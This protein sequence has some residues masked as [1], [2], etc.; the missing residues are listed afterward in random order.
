MLF[1]LNP[2]EAI[3][4]PFHDPEISTSL[5]ARFLAI[6]A[7][8]VS[9]V[10]SWD[11]TVLHWQDCQ[12][13][14]E[15]AA[16]EVEADI[17]PSRY[18][19]L[20]FS[21]TAPL[22]VSVRVEAKVDGSWVALGEAVRGSGIRMEVR[23]PFQKGHL[24]S[25]RACFTAGAAGARRIELHW[26]AVADAALSRQLLAATT[27]WDPAWPGLI[28]PD[29]N[30]RAVAFARGLVFDAAE[31]DRLRVKRNSPGWSDHFAILEQRA[32]R[33]MQRVPETDLGDYLPWSDIRYI[34]AREQGREP[35]FWEALTL[36]FVGLVNQDRAMQRHALRYLMCMVHT[37]NWCQS[38]ESRLT[39]STWDQRCFLEEMTV[40]SVAL[41]LD[42]FHFALTPHA[43]SLAVQALWDKGLSVIERDMM[44][45]DYVHYNN[46]GPWF[47]RARVL[48]GL[49]LEANWPR[50]GQ[51]TDRA[52]AAM[53]AALD[54]YIL[55][56]GGVDEGLGYFSVTLHATLTATIAF[57]R[58]RSLDVGSL[59]PK[60]L[61]K[62]ED[63]LAAMSA[64][65]PGKVLLDGDNST[66]YLIGDTIPIMAGLFPGSA[67][68]RIVAATLLKEGP[69]TYYNQYVLDGLLGFVLGPDE[70]PAAQ[71]IVP[72]FSV[73]PET[74]HLTS[75][76][77]DF[78]HSVRLHLAGS[79][80]NPSHSHLDKGGFT[81]ELDGVPFLIDRGTVRYDDARC[82]LLHR[83]AMH[84]V[85]TPCYD[86]TTFPDQLSPS[87][88]AIPSG[89]GDNGC[90]EAFIDLGNVWRGEMKECRRWISAGSLEAW[91]VRDAGS[92]PREGQV[93]FHLH[94]PFPFVIAG[95]TAIVEA[96]GIRLEID[97]PWAKELTACEDLIDY[98]FEPIYHLQIWSGAMV[99][100]D[101]TTNFRAFR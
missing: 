47:C 31:L 13:G 36:G 44:K 43:R 83:S 9:H 55:P 40:T 50:L 66:N 51:Y 8:G 48:G 60:N 58:A 27:E 29:G 28:E 30:W 16:V 98:R 95:N 89:H 4:A 77:R 49:M 56:D 74:G 94:S 87:W 86:G 45:F 5:P 64:V 53:S 80:A 79:K 26:F 68:E 6:H 7:T 96:G 82:E 72:V 70:L 62:S 67:Y 38:G 59:L 23:R 18:D 34:R 57:A 15:A 88:D 84:N 17:P 14:E 78:G 69:P 33:F 92:L 46:Q 20:I 10:Y 35:Y 71:S 73:L 93:V 12:A 41:L 37:K 99:D 61:L 22:D 90:L 65:E 2:A 3:F 11:R 63:F 1:P 81:V 85:L 97:A 91:T 54:H 76:R 24:H 101:F 39:G 100:F 19:E 52:F 75:L 21:L 32:R 25:A 42:W